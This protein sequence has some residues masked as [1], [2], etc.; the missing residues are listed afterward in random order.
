MSRGPHH[1][2]DVLLQSHALEMST[3]FYDD[4][5]SRLVRWITFMIQ[6]AN[7]SV[8]ESYPPPQTQ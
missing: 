2:D 5:W 3:D 4:S 7:Y 1:A 8:F 6:N